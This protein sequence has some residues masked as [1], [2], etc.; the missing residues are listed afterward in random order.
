[1]KVIGLNGSPRKNKN[2]KK[3]LENAL[4]GAASLGAETEIIDLFDLKYSGCLSCFA[5]KKLGH[6][7]FGR[8]AVND[9]LKPLLDKILNADAVIIAAPIY[10]GDVPGAVR[11][12]FERIWF[13]GLMYRKDG[14]IA[15]DKRVKVGLIYSMNIPKADR[16]QPLI[17][18]HVQNFSF[19]LGETKTLIVTDTLQ[20][21]DYSLYTG[22]V[23]SGE[24]KKARHESVFPEEC[25]KAYSLGAELAKD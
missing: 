13:P 15:Y 14:T 22:D 7:S 1:M 6:K 12:L 18:D 4:A 3:L 17:A 8:C 2:S 16:Y 21:D 5:C 19:F 11:N 23:F 10:F 20:Y 9:D 25:Q 24:H